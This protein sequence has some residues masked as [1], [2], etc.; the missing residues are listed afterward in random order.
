MSAVKPIP[1]D[2]RAATPY[3][4]VRGAAQALAFY[5][6]AF[7]AVETLRIE[8]GG[9]VGHAEFRIGEAP[10]ML[11]DEYPDMDIKSPPAYGG[12]PVT[13]HLYVADVDAFAARAVQAGLRVVR[14]VEDQFYGDRGGKFVDPFGHVW[15]LATR[16]ENLGNEEIRQ[17]AKAAFG[18]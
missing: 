1:D 7:G 8:A 17:R 5:K 13:I 16:K 12:S 14:P 3:L 6:A 18:G 10:I 9:Q 11:A 15:W 2:F 4:T